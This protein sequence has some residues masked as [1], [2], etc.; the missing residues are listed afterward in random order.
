V[1]IARWAAQNYETPPLG[2]LD[3]ADA[4]ALSGALQGQAGPQVLGSIAQTLKPDDM[5]LLLKDESFRAAV[6]GMS[7]SGDPAKMNAAYS[8]MDTLQKQNPLQFEKDFPD[9]LKYLRAWQ[10]NLAF[11]TPDEAAKRLTQALD[12]AQLAGREAAEKVADEALKSVSPDKVV[13][14]FST[15]WGPFGISARA[16]I[17]EQA[18]NAAGALKADY[19]LNYKAG[20]ALTGDPK[21]ADSYAMEKLNLK[22]AVSPTNNNRV[23]ANAPEYAVW[24]VITRMDPEVTANDWKIEGHYPKIDGSYDWMAKQLDDEV[25]KHLG[26]NNALDLTAAFASAVEPTAALMDERTPAER[27]YAAPRSIVSDE[28]TERDIAAGNPPSYKIILQDPNGRWGV[29]TNGGGGT[30]N[31]TNLRAADAALNLTPQEKGLYLTHLTNLAAGG[32]PNQGGLSTLFQASVEHDGQTYNIPTVW[33]GKILPIAEALKKVEQTGWNKFPAY[34]SSEAAEARY[35]QMHA[36]M[37]K[38]TGRY[39]QPPFAEGAAP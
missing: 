4:G 21:A 36:F 10:S 5:G 14:K 20:F 27:R 34:S 25:A 19:D 26:V 16:P 32:V 15:G 18:G 9:D 12:P 39:L 17:S 35:S 30:V 28:K 24:P 6:T 8:F 13:S 7:R 3:K 37:E 23:M 22:Y 11:Y 2:L 29:M 38:D 31:D 1:P 33:N